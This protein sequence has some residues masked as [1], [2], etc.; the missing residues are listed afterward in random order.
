[1]KPLT[2][3]EFERLLQ[4]RSGLRR[5]LRH[6]ERQ[7]EAAGMTP[8]QHELLLA[9]KGHPHPDGPTVGDVADYLVLRHHS[10]VGLIDRAAAAGLVERKPDRGSSAIVRLALTRTG[11]ERLQALVDAHR[12]ELSR[13]VPT[14]RALRKVLDRSGHADSLA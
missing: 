8:A 6:T 13:L 4:L 1:M 12:E 2:Q 3:S 11:V 7:A 9:I 10:A 5:I 14:M